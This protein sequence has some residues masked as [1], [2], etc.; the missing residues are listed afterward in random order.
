MSK[1][2]FCYYYKQNKKKQNSQIYPGKLGKK[3]FNEI[4]QCAWE[5]WI[6]QQT[7]IINE[8]KLNMFDINHRKKIE[9]YMINFL[10]K[11]KK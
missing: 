8:K 4:S 6:N 5:K 3:I 7:K 9:T 2:I 1:K 11:N 10:F